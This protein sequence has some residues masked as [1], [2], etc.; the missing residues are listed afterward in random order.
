[1]TVEDAVAT[2]TEATPMT[3]R[4][5]PTGFA[6]VPPALVAFVCT[7]FIREAPLRTS[8]ALDDDHEGRS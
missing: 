7:L 4:A 6:R 8:D 1:M 2:R 3:P 5:D